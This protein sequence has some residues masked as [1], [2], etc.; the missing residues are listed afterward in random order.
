MVGTQ[1]CVS[2]A[3]QVAG[4]LMLCRRR[5]HPITSPKTTCRQGGC[6]HRHAGNA[7]PQTRPSLHA[8][9]RGDAGALSALP[10]GSGAPVRC[11]C[12]SPTGLVQPG[13]ST[14]YSSEERGRFGSGF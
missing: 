10:G 3:R 11:D 12:S 14:A 7:T 2:S 9:A 5:G 6:S 1:P 8:Q 13:C 4:S